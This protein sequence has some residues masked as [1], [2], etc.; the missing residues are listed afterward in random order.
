[1]FDWGNGRCMIGRASA[2]DNQDIRL[3]PTCWM[4]D[5]RSRLNEYRVVALLNDGNRFVEHQ[6]MFV[7]SFG[8]RR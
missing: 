3:W 1:M 6:T 4:F 5:A 8:A 2:S 7:L